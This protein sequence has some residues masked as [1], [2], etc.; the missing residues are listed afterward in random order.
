MYYQLTENLMGVQTLRKNLYAALSTVRESSTDQEIYFATTTIMDGLRRR[1]IDL[2]PTLSSVAE[3]RGLH[4]QQQLIN[5]MQILSTQKHV[6][7]VATP[8]MNALK[9]LKINSKINLTENLE[10]VRTIQQNKPLGFVL[11]LIR[12]K[13]PVCPMD[14]RLF[15]AILINVPVRSS[16]SQ[17]RYDL[18]QSLRDSQ[19]PKHVWDATIQNIPIRKES[20][21]RWLATVVKTIGTYT[22]NNEMVSKAA[23]GIIQLGEEAPK[24]KLGAERWR[25]SI[26]DQLEPNVRTLSR[27]IAEYTLSIIRQYRDED[28]KPE[29]KIF[30]RK[31]NIFLSPHDMINQ[32]HQQIAMQAN[33]ALSSSEEHSGE[34]RIA[35]AIVRR[36]AADNTEAN[37][38]VNRVE[39]K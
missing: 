9:G 12:E 38:N 17:A 28:K 34:T 24:Q 10:N 30:K 35:M 37:E 27:A 4:P 21:L 26:G 2:Y 29:P 13:V 8:V 1:H 15:G 7:C 5:V 36:N 18:F 3:L 31:P 39:E 32:I 14:Q 16:V 20:L 6:H 33:N 23:D 19:L 11:N 25:R 22:N